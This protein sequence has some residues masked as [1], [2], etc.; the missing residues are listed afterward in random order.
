MGIFDDFGKKI[1]QTSQNLINKAN[2]LADQTKLN[3]Q[4]NE[5]NKLIQNLYASLGQSYYS[6][7]KDAP[8]QEVAQICGEI[9]AAMERIEA[10]QQQVNAVRKVTVC[11]NC[12]A[13][14]PEGSAF[15]GRC[16]TAIPKP[17]P[18]PQP[19]AA[20]TAQGES[21]FC[22]KCGYELPANAV[23]CPKCGNKE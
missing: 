13:E 10:L 11:P 9:T 5:Q 23:F 22:S 2:D 8:A 21:R 12:G 17:E 3:S 19:E 15:C 1:S 14:A 4:I 20:P 7:H 18:I 16:G 6:Y